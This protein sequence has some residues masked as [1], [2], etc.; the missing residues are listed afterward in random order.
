[1]IDRIKATFPNLGDSKQQPLIVFVGFLGGVASGSQD[2]IAHVERLKLIFPGLD[3]VGDL[4]EQYDAARKA[5]VIELAAPDSL[6]LKRSVPISGMQQQ[7][8]DK[9]RKDDNF[10]ELAPVI[11][12]QGK[13][14]VFVKGALLQKGKAPEEINQ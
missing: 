5:D 12:K 7:L 14:Y 11:G 6:W 13:V 3:L 4:Q 10:A 2:W 1:M 8:L 9:M